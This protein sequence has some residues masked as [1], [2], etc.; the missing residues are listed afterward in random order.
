MIGLQRRL[1]PVL[2]TLLAPVGEPDS[3]NAVPERY[4]ALTA[5]FDALRRCP[6]VPGA[7]AA[8][9]QL[10]REECLEHWTEDTINSWYAERD[11]PKH[12]PPKGVSDVESGK[13]GGWRSG[14]D[15][16]F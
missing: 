6:D 9:E 7:L 3:P 10:R 2:Q 1:E 5:Q 11:Q 4:L 16:G 8:W 14:K 13:N 15:G 12:P